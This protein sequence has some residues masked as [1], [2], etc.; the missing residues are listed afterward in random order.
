[1]INPSRYVYK[2][3]IQKFVQLVLPNMYDIGPNMFPGP[4]DICW[5]T[6]AVK[7]VCNKFQHRKDVSVIKDD[8]IFSLL[9]D[10]KIGFIYMLYFLL[11][12]TTCSSNKKAYK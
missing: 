12:L 6:F 11:G 9:N 5:E 1:M 4:G 2:Y 7:A 3:N 8:T 10:L